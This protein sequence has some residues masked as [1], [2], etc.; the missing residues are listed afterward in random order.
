MKQRNDL[1]IGALI[2]SP[3]LQDS[4]LKAMCDELSIP[5]SPKDYAWCRRQAAK[6][7]VNKAMGELGLKTRRPNTDHDLTD[8]YCAQFKLPTGVMS[9]W[10][11][12]VLVPEHRAQSI[13]PGQI[14]KCHQKS[15]YQTWPVTYWSVMT[16]AVSERLGQSI[17]KGKPLD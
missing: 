6:R 5:S 9:G 8:C 17:V 14:I 1:L 2:Q 15:E 3:E 13:R 4:E 12:R 10:G 7:K 16:V 11:I